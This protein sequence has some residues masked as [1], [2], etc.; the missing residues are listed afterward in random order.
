MNIYFESYKKIVIILVNLSSAKTPEREGSIYA[1]MHSMHSMHLCY[2]QL[3]WA[4]ARLLA[5]PVSLIYL[6]DKFFFM[7]LV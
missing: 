1:S 7:F 6:V 2:L 4:T 3:F 5:T